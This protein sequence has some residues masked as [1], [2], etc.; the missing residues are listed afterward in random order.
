MI[1]SARCGYQ[2]ASMTHLLERMI[3]SKTLSS[4][5][6]YTQEQIRKRLDNINSALNSNR[7]KGNFNNFEKRWQKHMA[8]LK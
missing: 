6:H 2:P 3:K 1:F 7:W 5:D 4:N 8:D